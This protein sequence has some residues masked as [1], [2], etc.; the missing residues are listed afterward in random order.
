MPR[1][2]RAVEAI[3]AGAFGQPAA[4]RAG[5][6]QRRSRIHRRR[7]ARLPA[8]GRTALR[9]RQP[10]SR[11]RPAGA[12]LPHLCLHEAVRSGDRISDLVG[13]RRR[14]S[15]ARSGWACPT[16]RARSSSTRTTAAFRW[17]RT[18]GSGNGRRCWRGTAA[19]RRA[20][21]WGAATPG[22]PQLRIGRPHAR[23]GQAEL[24]AD[25]VGALDQ[26]H[27]LVEGDAP[28]QALAAEAAIGADDEL[29]LGDVF[30]RLADQR[31][32]VLGRLDHRVAMVDHA[33]ARSSCRS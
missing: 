32:H 33:D 11:H 1:R 18:P 27:A 4:H 14:I 15:T 2:L 9:V 8:G 20:E 10:R 12:A 22:E 21:R 7:H 23:F 26:R 3:A 17:W 24:A 5:A 30:Q 25:D 13:R 28:R 19:N 16:A 31:R 29:L 6:G